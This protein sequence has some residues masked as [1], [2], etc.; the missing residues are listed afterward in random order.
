M[1]E[2]KVKSVEGAAKPAVVAL[3]L[4][5]VIKIGTER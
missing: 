1:I 5:K 2:N 4:V 3:L